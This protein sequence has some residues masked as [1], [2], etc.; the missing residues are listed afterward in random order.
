MRTMIADLSSD[1]LIRVFAAEPAMPVQVANEM[2]AAIDKLFL[3]FMREGRCQTAAAET[4][5]NGRFLVIAWEGPPLSGCSHDKIAQ[6]ITAYEARC[7]CALLTAPPIAIGERAA[8]RVTNRAGLRASLAS[9][10]C[11]SR[12]PVWNL[13]AAT[14]GEW[15]RGPVELGSSIWASVAQASSGS[16]GTLGTT[17]SPDIGSVVS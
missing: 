1:A 3:Q 15:R 10:A 4:E 13:R 8:V 6:V 17:G 11:D 2:V 14:V 7:G 16:A 5:A 12:T 9:G